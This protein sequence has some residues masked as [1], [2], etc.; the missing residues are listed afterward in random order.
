MEDGRLV[1]SD[2]GLATDLAGVGTLMVGTPFYMAP[3]LIMGEQSSTRSDV[4]AMG[5]VLHELF[6]G[7]RPDWE[8]RDYRRVMRSP[9]TPDSNRVER[10]VFEL[11]RA[12]T[13]DIPEERPENGEALSLL[14]ERALAG[15][16]SPSTPSSPAYRRRAGVLWGTTTLLGLGALILIGR[17]FGLRMRQADASSAAASA[18]TIDVSGASRRALPAA[19]EVLDV[20]GELHCV[21]A[22][23]DEKSLVV[24]WGASRTAEE[25]DLITGARRPTTL[26]AETY[27]LGCPEIS[28]QSGAVLF[29]ADGD[30]N[31]GRIIKVIERPGAAAHTLTAGTGPLWIPHSEDFVFNIDEGHAAVYSFAQ[32]NFALAISTD[33]TEGRT[34]YLKA[35][36]PDGKYLATKHLGGPS[37]VTVLVRALPS[38]EVTGQVAVGPRLSGL[39]FSADN[40]FLR[41]ATSREGKNEL[42]DVDWRTGK[43]A[44]CFSTTVGGSLRRDL[45]TSVGLVG[46]GDTSKYQIW[47]ANKDAL[48]RPLVTEGANFF[49]S[50]DAQGNVLF[51]SVDGSGARIIRSWDPDSGT[52]KTLTNGPYDLW[53]NFAPSG[54]GWLYVKVDSNTV[55]HCPHLHSAADCVPLAVPPHQVFRPALSPDMRHL[56]YL[57]VVGSALRASLYDLGS[58]QIGDLGPALNDE[59][60]RFSDPDH[61]WFL[62]ESNHKR[63]WQEFSLA[64]QKP[65]GRTE[66]MDPV[67]GQTFTQCGRF[68]FP[69]ES[70]AEWA[71]NRPDLHA[72]LTVLTPPAWQ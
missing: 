53:P 66:L 36:S 44:Q 29:E 57:G 3:E 14:L 64:A 22:L 40:G 54:N 59:A 27:K 15:K 72:H 24:V 25:V 21:S 1:L 52:T 46:V 9:L 12:A 2:F 5:V 26:P 69:S 70:S 39:R 49:P 51:V 16:R 28:P 20:E 35:V 34:L 18:K 62:T 8:W 38:L 61:V 50:R 31:L 10:R 23:P 71:C 68:P 63:S 45:A 65:T 11:C 55:M 17:G 30:G 48:E 33:P 56:V 19:R 41:F 58:Q 60:P 6:F 4:W 67:L 42:C 32:R 47:L 43:T 13:I 37:G 7:L